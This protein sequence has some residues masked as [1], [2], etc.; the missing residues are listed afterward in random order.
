MTPQRTNLPGC[1]PGMLQTAGRSWPMGATVDVG[2]VNFAVFSA[3]AS[4]IELCLFSDDGRKEVARLLFQDRDGDVWHMRVE[5]MMP[6]QR[7]GLR[8]HGPYAPEDGHRFNPHKL[9]M[10]P[11]ARAFDGRLRWSDALMGYR[12]G[13]S[14]GDLSF[15]TRDSAFAVPKSVVVED[16]ADWGKD[17]A[18]RRPW[19]ET[20][21]YEAHVKG[22]T[23]RNSR[24]QGA[25]RGKY[26]GIASPAMIEHYHRLGITAIE[27]LPVQAFFDDRFLVA[28][29]LTNYWG[30]NTMG[31]FAPA[32]RSLLHENRPVRP[33]E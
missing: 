16:Q 1:P 10:D 4:L 7:Y 28:R 20:V 3:N 6:G 24:V 26:V 27:L 19:S 5:G 30:Y 33:L 18:P 25:A 21:I 8:A 31:F 15:D 2:G 22:L 12:V 29:G 17:A 14:R 32:P 9:L 23:A 11:Y 13:A